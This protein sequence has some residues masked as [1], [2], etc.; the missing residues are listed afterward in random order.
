M[1]NFYYGLPKTKLKAL[2]KIKSKRY[3][4]TFI[5]VYLNVLKSTRCEL[6]GKT[7]VEVH[8]TKTIYGEDTLQILNNLADLKDI[9]KVK[10]FIIHMHEPP[11][12]LTFVKF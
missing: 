6:L 7:G 8:D 4:N 5:K 1:P 3:L 12:Y 9:L 11:Y 2:Y 10:L